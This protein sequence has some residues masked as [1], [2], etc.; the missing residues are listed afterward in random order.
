VYVSSGA[1]GFL[2][3]AGA[4]GRFTP[5]LACPNMVERG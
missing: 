4:D 3:P 5:N 2:L 1:M